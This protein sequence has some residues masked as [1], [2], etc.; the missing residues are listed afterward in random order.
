MSAPFRP[1]LARTVTDADLRKLS[2]P[3]LASPKYDGIRALVRGG[4][5]LSRRLLDVPSRVARDL[6]AR[7][8]LEGVDGE[9][10]LGAPV[11]PGCYHRTESAVMSASGQGAGSLVL[12]AFDLFDDPRPYGQRLE[13]LRRRVDGGLRVRVVPTHVLRG[14]EDLAAYEQVMQARGWEGVMLRD[15]VSAYKNG[16]STLRE[17][18]LLRRKWTEQAEGVLVGINEAEENRNPATVSALGY[19]KRSSSKSGRVPKGIAGSLLVR[20]EEWGDVLVGPG[21]LTAAERAE[22]LR[23]PDRRLGTGLT[24]RFQ[25][26]GTRDRPRIP[27]FVGWRGA[28]DL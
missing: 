6:F 8:S 18:A 22:L 4:R 20:T 12:Y 7:R 3:L 14:P 27:T 11:S 2:F 23:D 9:L 26:V 15:P 25:R 19:T 10:V 13:A 16:R 17:A 24:F 1:M 21:A 28:H 5:L